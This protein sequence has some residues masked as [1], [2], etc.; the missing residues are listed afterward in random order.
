MS[1]LE[2]AGKPSCLVNVS[3]EKGE[4]QSLLV[5]KLLSKAAEAGLSKEGIVQYKN[6]LLQEA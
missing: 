4:K 5:Q 6:D 2:K 3:M 1:K